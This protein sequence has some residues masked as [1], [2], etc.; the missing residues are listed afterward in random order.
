MMRFLFSEI[1]KSD[2]L[3]FSPTKAKTACI[4]AVFK[5]GAAERKVHFALRIFRY[6][7]RPRTL[8]QSASS[9]SAASLFPLGDIDSGLSLPP[10]IRFLRY[11]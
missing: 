6:R 1:K 10:K 3:G 9:I 11:H 7:S 8:F 2:F 5:N 4:E